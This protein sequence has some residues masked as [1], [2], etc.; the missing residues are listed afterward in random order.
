MKS[1]L[2]CMERLHRCIL[3]NFQQANCPNR[4]VVTNAISISELKKTYGSSWVSLRR[5]LA[6]QWM[7]YPRKPET[8]TL[9]LGNDA[10]TRLKLKE[11]N[12]Q[13]WSFCLMLHSCGNWRF[14]SLKLDSA[15]YF[16]E[17]FTARVLLQ[18]HTDIIYLSAFPMWPLVKPQTHVDDVI[19]W[20]HDLLVGALETSGSCPLYVTPSFQTSGSPHNDPEGF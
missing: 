11:F 5:S 17:S 16:E 12:L 19:S 14:S 4:Q 2:W 7:V 10:K 13:V 20:K 18:L 1:K 9:R 8:D 15:R 6:Q 3:H